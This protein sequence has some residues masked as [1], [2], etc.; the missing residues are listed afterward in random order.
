MISLFCQKCG[1]QNPDDASFCGKCGNSLK[2]GSNKEQTKKITLG[3]LLSWIFGIFFGLI[4]IAFVVDGLFGAGIPSIIIS[5]FLLPPI[6]KL[7][8]SKFNFDLSKGVKITF[9]IILFIISVI[10]VPN[11]ELS[12]NSKVTQEPTP[13]TKYVSETPTPTASITRIK[14]DVQREGRYYNDGE[15]ISTM[16][17]TNVGNV[18]LTNFVVNINYFRASGESFNSRRIVFGDIKV[19]AFEEREVREPAKYLGQETWTTSEV[20]FYYNNHTID[21]YKCP[22]KGDCS[23][24][25]TTYVE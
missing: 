17:I 25:K 18:D 20:L 4:G 3:L 14:Y 19:D 16:K 10:N 6:N 8:A 1:T 2:S 13:T 22:E 24:M 23:F 9:V 7:I 12:D 15:Y 21:T 11:N 5:I